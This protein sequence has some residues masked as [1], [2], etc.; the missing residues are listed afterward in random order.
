MN[1][2]TLV[3]RPPP[4]LPKSKMAGN[5][6]SLLHCAYVELRTPIGRRRV[7]EKLFM[8]CLPNLT[9]LVLVVHRKDYEF[10]RNLHSGII[11]GEILI[12]RNT[13]EWALIK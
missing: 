7:A 2:E 8:E 5:N 13:Q 1:T 10:R 6:P 3:F 12:T 11:T 9:R 4:G